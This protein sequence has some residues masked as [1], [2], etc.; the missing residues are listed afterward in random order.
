M[1]L[2]F[3]KIRRRIEPKEAKQRSKNRFQL[4]KNKFKQKLLN[5][6]NFVSLRHF[7]P[8]SSLPHLYLHRFCIDMFQIQLHH[9]TTT[10]SRSPSRKLGTQR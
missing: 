6:I 7:S 4:E 2:S 3:F 9:A 10:T 8:N 5:Q 1:E